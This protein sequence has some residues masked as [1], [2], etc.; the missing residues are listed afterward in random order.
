MKKFWTILC[1]FALILACPAFAE[2]AASDVVTLKVFYSAPNEYES[3]SW[4][5]DPV[6]RWVTEQTGIALDITFASTADHQEFYTLL[7]SD[8]I[9]EYDM[10]Y[11]GRYE[12]TLVDEGYVLALTDLADEYCPEY[13]DVIS[14]EELAIHSIDGKMYYTTRDYANPEQLE[15]LPGASKAFSM[16]YNYQVMDELGVDPA[17]IITLADVEEIAKRMRDELG[18][19]YPIYLNTLGIT[20]NI[21]YLQ[22][23]SGSSFAAP[24]VVYP[25]ADG[26]VTYNVKSEEYKA[27]A[28]WLNQMYKEGLIKADNFTHTTSINDET[29]K[30]IAQSGDLGFVLGHMWVINQHR[31]E[32]NGGGIHGNGEMGLLQFAGQTPLAEGVSIEDIQCSDQN[33]SN[34][35]AAAW[36]VLDR[37]E[38]PAECIRFIT[39]MFT[40]ESQ[41]N[42]MYGLEGLGYTIEYNEMFDREMMTPTPEYTADATQ[43]SAEDLRMKYGNLIPW[44]TTFRTSYGQNW[45]SV[46]QIV[47]EENGVKKQYGEMLI[48]IGELYGSPFKTGNLTMNLTDTDQLLLKTNVEE[49]WSNNIALCV[50]ADDFEAAYDKML[51]DMETVGLS[52]LEEIYTERYWQYDDMLQET[53]NDKW[54]DAAAR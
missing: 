51:A 32:G 50:L 1:A 6:S 26:T 47:I 46:P 34:I 24:G 4:G 49:A 12:P 29:V 14:A 3:W 36:Y 22:I 28:A 41:R 5:A 52:E 40:E 45:A 11:L 13:Y 35:G 9:S 23:L 38:H 8:M 53:R 48:N 44:K 10:L 30:N 17:T 27:A 2:D 15:S 31:P 54:N 42:D 25:Q 18:I 20:N 33:L 39:F 16:F 43:L 7:A 21:D 37:T 19:T